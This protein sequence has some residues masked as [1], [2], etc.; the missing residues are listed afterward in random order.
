MTLITKQQ[1][2]ISNHTTILNIHGKDRS[3]LISLLTL[4]LITLTGLSSVKVYGSHGSH[5][6]FVS[7][8]FSPDVRATGSMNII[9]FK[10][11]YQIVAVLSD[12]LINIYFQLP[13]GHR[14]R[15]KHVSTALLTLPA[16]IPDSPP[17]PRL[18]VAAHLNCRFT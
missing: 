17:T 14:V 15:H 1:T 6:C 16:P 2:L 5:M 4:L 11:K 12:A 13:E 9:E 10:L 3:C 18:A 7:L 8:L